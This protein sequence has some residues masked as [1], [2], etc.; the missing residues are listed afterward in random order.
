MDPLNIVAVAEMRRN[1]PGGHGRELAD[2]SLLEFADH[3]LLRP[4]PIACCPYS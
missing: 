1:L 2:R 3:N 4:L